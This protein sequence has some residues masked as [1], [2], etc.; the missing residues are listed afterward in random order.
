MIASLPAND[1]V[2]AKA[3][4]MTLCRKA[5]MGEIDVPETND[6]GE[7]VPSLA[8]TIRQAIANGEVAF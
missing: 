3:N 8:V 7:D 4:H 6:D 1:H 2:T 5:A